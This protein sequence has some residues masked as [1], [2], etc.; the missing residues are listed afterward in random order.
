VAQKTTGPRLCCER[1][2]IQILGPWLIGSL[3]Q[4]GRSRACVHGWRSEALVD[5]PA[6]TW[7]RTVTKTKPK[8]L[9]G[10]RSY[11][12]HKPDLAWRLDP[13]HHVRSS[14]AFYAAGGL[15]LAGPRR[16]CLAGMS[17]TVCF[18]AVALG[19]PRREALAAK[20]RAVPPMEPF[21][22]KHLSGL[23]GA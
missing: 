17:S 4:P 6:G 1:H 23:E 16:T 3:A 7:S 18:R 10:L 20:S 8:S 11:R 9:S 13:L 21:Q 19:R 2:S 15:K 22:E 5:K 14:L 12:A